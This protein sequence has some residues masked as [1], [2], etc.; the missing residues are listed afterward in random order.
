MAGAGYVVPSSRRVRL[1]HILIT[2]LHNL[3]IMVVV[4]AAMVRLRLLPIAFDADVVKDVPLALAV[5]LGL[6][7]LAALW[8]IREQG[9]VVRAWYTR[10]HGVYL[11]IIG[12]LVLGVGAIVVALGGVRVG[13]VDILVAADLDVLVLVGLLGVGTQIFLAARLP[14]IFDLGSGAVRSFRNRGTER[15]APPSGTPPV[16]YAAVI[17]LLLAVAL[18][19]VATRFDLGA[20]FGNFQDARIA[21][22]V[23]VFPL[24]LVAFFTISALQI[25]REGRR[26]FYRKK[27][28]A[29]ARTT[30]LVYGVAA[31][32]GLFFS[33]L[34]IMNL[35]GALTHIG[36]VP[37]GLTLSKD[38]ILL[39]ILGTAG[40]VGIFLQRQNKRVD[41]IEERLPDFL[42]DLAET[43][44]A[45]LTLAASLQSCALA[46]YGP[47][48]KE[49]RKMADQV[50]WGVGFNEALAQFAGR[51]KTALVVRTSSLIIEAS[52]AGGSVA[53]ILKA[54]ARDAH[55]IKGLE[56]ERR[57]SMATYLIVIYVVFA[58]FL[59]VLAV[60]AVQFIP[61]VIASNQAVAG[62]SLAGGGAAPIGSSAG[63][64]RQ[65]IDFSY[66]LAATVQAIGN[67]LVGGV[68]T[69][70]RVTAGFRHVA[71]M[72]VL[73]WLVF[74]TLV[75]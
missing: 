49:I 17:A 47:L 16:V 72:S 40:P 28:T 39:T 44:R 57:T 12:G 43:K 67:G 33:V 35:S 27:V 60:L 66:F 2:L 61:Q 26:G 14:T 59:G 55:Q 58:V 32:L 75:P 1:L 63:L 13:G 7:A 23:L 6:L 36:P 24:F 50:A 68:L 52:R 48:S 64:D 51:I 41:G 74:R 25:R 20:L 73:A 4:L 29:Q 65:A 21:L 30:L 31:A 11:G 10:V 46:D 18:G 71:I 56:V 15:G 54:A 22:V 70:G 62:S 37:G 9:G 53:E 34:L 8:R 19:Y 42:N 69:E 45:G 3:G 38:L 5:Y